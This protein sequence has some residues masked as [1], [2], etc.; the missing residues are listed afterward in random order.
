MLIT[1]VLGPAKSVGQVVEDDVEP[2]VCASH[3]DGDAGAR[4]AELA[5]GQM[6]V[7]E[8]DATRARE[9]LSA[10]RSEVQEMLAEITS[11]GQQDRIADRETGDQVDTAQ[12]LVSEGVDDAV[13]A[14][15]RRRLDALDRAEKRLAEGTYGLSVRSGEPIPDE[16]L[17]VEPTA[18]LTVEEARRRA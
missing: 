14:Q 4:V 11:A 17:E 7:A 2:V 18:E 15:L 10:E 13:E 12:P 1:L 3:P 16:R 6:E 5:H 8:M 9:L